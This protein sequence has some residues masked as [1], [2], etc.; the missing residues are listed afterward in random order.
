MT[1]RAAN[2]LYS[3]SEVVARR[4]G[5]AFIPEGRPIV[6]AARIGAAVWLA[7]RLLDLAHQQPLWL[8]G[9]TCAWC[10]AAW[11]AQPT[12]SPPAAND[13][14][15]DEPDDTLTFEQATDVLLPRIR[16]LIGTA[17]GVHLATLLEES[18][19]DGQLPPGTTVAELRRDLTLR[20]IPT[21]SSLKVGGTVLVGIHRDDLPAA[22]EPLPDHN[23]A[24]AG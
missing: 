17:N 15:P 9:G 8:V 10:I 6:A 11:R 1:A 21:R 12:H 20:G 2:R 5:R 13:N 19:A 24:L 16:A 18:I 23:H 7:P 14:E 4:I 3:G 22:A